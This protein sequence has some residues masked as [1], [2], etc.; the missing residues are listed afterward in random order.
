MIGQLP[1][2]QKL[3]AGC[4]LPAEKAYITL[5]RYAD[6]QY[7]SITRHMLSSNFEAK[8]S[9]L[10]K[11]KVFTILPT[12]PC[13]T[14]PPTPGICIFGIHCVSFLN[15]FMQEEAKEVFKLVAQKS[16]DFRYPDC[17]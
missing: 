9:L 16:E 8:K 17:S 4:V 1:S 10:R 5:A 6:V 12:A 3:L 15:L 14:Q 11:S 13:V 2:N 7:Q